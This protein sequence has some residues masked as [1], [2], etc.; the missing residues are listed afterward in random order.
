MVVDFPI[1]LAGELLELHYQ[2]V[3]KFCPKGVFRRIPKVI[4]EILRHTIVPSTTVEE[5]AIGWPFLEI[6]YA[7][8]SSD[9]RNLVDLMVNQMLECK[10]DVR[11]PLAL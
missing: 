6:I 5:S 10:Q 1:L 4:Y 7:M 2:E 3:S 11:A 9:K 8:M